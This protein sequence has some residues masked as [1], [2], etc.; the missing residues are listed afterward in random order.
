MTNRLSLEDAKRVQSD[1]NAVIQNLQ[2]KGF[3]LQGG[4]MYRPKNGRMVRNNYQAHDR[5]PHE[6]IYSDEEEDGGFLP[7]AAAVLAIPTAKVVGKLGY[8]AYKHVKNN[9]GGELD[10][11]P[12]APPLPE[13]R[14]PKSY[15]SYQ[16]NGSVGGKR[17]RKPSA[18]HTHV[19]NTANETGL[20][21]AELF[22]E[23]SRT[24]RK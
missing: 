11:A 1:I 20:R 16:G 24:Y 9:R 3:T 7:A 23:A 5:Y 4:K 15:L 10:D 6:D 12:R 21:G 8:K 14:Q 18:W 19:A 22:R 13:K 17:A 2:Q